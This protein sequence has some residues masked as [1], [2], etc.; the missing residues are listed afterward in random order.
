MRPQAR[1]RSQ[2]TTVT[3]AGIALAGVVLSSRHAT[4]AFQLQLAETGG[5]TLLVSDN[6]AG[7]LNPAI[8][9]IQ[10]GSGSGISF[11]DFTLFGLMATSNRTS[12][13]GN[14]LAEIA[15]SSLTVRNNTAAP[16][17]LGLTAGDTDFTFPTVRP[18]DLTSSASGT[19]AVVPGTG[20]TSVGGSSATVTS[21]AD[22]A[23]G[24][25]AT[26]FPAENFAFNAPASP[27][28]SFADP[29]ATAGG[30]NPA[31]SY[32]MTLAD[33]FTVAGNTQL[34]SLGQ[35]L[36]AQTGPI[37]EPSSLLLLGAAPLV[38]AQRPSRKR[39]RASRSH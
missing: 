8:G 7:D 11:G 9:V 6:S 34:V 13:S 17:A 16:H 18:L 37:P 10:I 38:A 15:L 19:F 32:S 33:Q 29:V 1:S 3:A 2:L 27:S 39:S 24:Q 22:A 14:Q 30:F 12:G 35:V 5:P 26:A 28:A 23:N 20:A 31:G 21:F 4:A 25:F 36:S